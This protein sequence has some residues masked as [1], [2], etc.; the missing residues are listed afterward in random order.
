MAGQR[1]GVARRRRR[2]C[3]AQGDGR[4][5]QADVM[6]GEGGV[7]MAL[8]KLD[9]YT[10]R[11]RPEDLAEIRRFYVEVLGL[12]DGARPPFSFPG[13]W[14]YC[15][16]APVVH[17]AG[18]AERTPAPESG[19]LDHIAFGASGLAQMRRQLAELEVAFDE[20]T[21]PGLGLHQLFVED[22]NGIKIELNYPAAEAQAAE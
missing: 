13:H 8:E 16:G 14:L 7:A 9:H 17:L 20:R 10:I 21:V 18:T 22:P 12:D 6:A 1:T 15:G 3:R 4:R 2:L 19:R 5:A 11:V